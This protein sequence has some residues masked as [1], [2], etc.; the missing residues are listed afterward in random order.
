MGE[1]IARRLKS[2]ALVA[3]VAAVCAISSASAQ[4]EPLI[5]ADSYPTTIDGTALAASI[6]TMEGGYKW[7]C[8]ATA[9]SGELVAKSGSL[10]LSPTYGECRWNYPVLEPPVWRVVTVT[11]NGCD[12]LLHG[13]KRTEADKY[14]TLADLKC[15]AGQQVVVHLSSTTFPTCKVTLPAQSNLAGSNLID[16]TG[17]EKSA[18]DVELQLGMGGMAFTQDIAGCPVAVG[19]HSTF[20]IVNQ[21]TLSGTSGGKGV[22]LRVSGE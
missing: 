4:A 9:M 11:M 5:E 20:S 21:M 12:Y 1:R 15:P 8:K 10:T 19:A 3:L 6:F 16:K 17:K 2:T 18:D 22:G 7:E 13:L 14:S